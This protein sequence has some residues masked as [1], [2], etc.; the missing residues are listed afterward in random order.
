VLFQQIYTY[1]RST[2]SNEAEYERSNEKSDAV[3]D[4]QAAASKR[5]N[6]F[7]REG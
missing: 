3:H 4:E 2:G 7:G 6:D 5:T 1:F